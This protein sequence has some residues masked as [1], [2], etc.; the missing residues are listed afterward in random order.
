MYMY[1]KSPRCTISFVSYTSI[2][3]KKSFLEKTELSYLEKNK[4]SLNQVGKFC[5]YF[6]IMFIIH[7]QYYTYEKLQ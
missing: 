2:K 1:V 3:L 5:K 7:C 4:W 6:V